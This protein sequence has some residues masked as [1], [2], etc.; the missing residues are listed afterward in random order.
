MNPGHMQHDQTSTRQRHASAESFESYQLDQLSIQEDNPQICRSQARRSSKRHKSGEISTTLLDKDAAKVAAEYYGNCFTQGVDFESAEY[1]A[2]QAHDVYKKHW[3]QETSHDYPIVTSVGD[4][5]AVPRYGPL[6]APTL[7]DDTP[8]KSPAGFKRDL[9]L[10]EN[11]VIDSR[12]NSNYYIAN[13]YE[14]TVP[15]ISRSIGGSAKETASLTLR[16]EMKRLES[17]NDRLFGNIHTLKRS[18][19]IPFST[20]DLCVRLRDDNTSFTLEE[21]SQQNMHF[22]LLMKDERP[23]FERSISNLSTAETE[24]HSNIKKNSDS[25]DKKLSFDILNQDGLHIDHTSAFEREKLKRKQIDRRGSSYQDY[26]ENS[27]TSDNDSKT[28]RNDDHNDYSQIHCQ[29]CDSKKLSTILNSPS[30]LL[31]TGVAKTLDDAKLSLIIALTVSNGDVT[32]KSFLSA[33]E[34][35]TSLYRSTGLDARDCNRGNVNSSSKYI[36]GNW[37]TLSR[38]NYAE[39]LG[40]NA[41]NEF[42]Y[43]LGRMSFDMFTPGNLVCSIGGVF[44]SI[45]VV[46]I[47]EGLSSVKSIP[48]GLKSEVLKGDCLLRRYE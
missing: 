30:P 18:T 31:T 46:D 6:N 8:K 27:I 29:G 33:L 44:N 15:S 28:E 45:D 14:Y 19:Q 2:K 1:N 5:F 23:S 3:L 9:R 32:S 13:D 48:K 40:T 42:M 36:E 12:I 7:E 24:I 11:D 35:L 4:S 26:W 47:R 10:Q 43:T 38:P 21:R 37:L 17:D 41:N 39:C 34:E 20:I 25:V 16:D 22:E